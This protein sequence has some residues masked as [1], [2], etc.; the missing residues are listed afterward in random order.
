MVETAALDIYNDIAERTN[1]DIYIGVV[2]PVR[3]GK[4]TFITSFMEKLILPNVKN[5]NIK[6]RAID[7]LP[8]SAEGKTIMTTQ[9]KFVPNEAVRL[10]LGD[11]IDVSA[12]LIDCVGYL[13]DGAM[14][15]EENQKARLV[16]TPWSKD[17]IPFEEAAEIGTQKVVSE[18]STIAVVVT[19]DGSITEIARQSYI[20]AEKRVVNEL[21]QLNKPFIVVL[22]STNP[23]SNECK[24]LAN[25]MSAEYGVSV[26]PLDVKNITVS[27][28]EFLLKSI[29]DEFPV[30][31][32]VFDI[33]KW[34]R[35][36][37]SDNVLICGIID[38]IKAYADDVNKMKNC[39]LLLSAFAEDENF[40]EPVV[41]SLK[42]GS[43]EA[44]YSIQAKPELFFK[45]LSAQAGKDISDEF[46]LMSFVT[47]CSVARKNYDNIKDAMESAAAVG[48]GVVSPQFDQMTLYDPEIVKAGTR[49]G[50]KLKA[51]APT[52]HI[53]RV[54]VSTE[55][56]PMVGSEQQ[57]QYLL[58][59]FQNNPKAI[60]E[61]DMFGKSLASLAR[62]G[63]ANKV[64]AMPIDAQDKLIKTVGRIINEGKG[65][66]ICILL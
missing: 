14:G 29:L 7:E 46:S 32:M 55:V 30:K 41:E 12:R 62:E 57:S 63:L 10:T 54:D 26:L 23:K 28:I 52:L 18:H 22:N 65:S 58:S 51:S 45:T 47:E 35:T 60:W 21:K 24:E 48:Y 50:V 5:K 6:K 66:L 27:Q 15:H 37:P 33:P 3:T 2:G 19:T 56:N 39:N 43:G 34:M 4:S 44:Y 38:K 49:F 20:K 17:S 13:V 64:N 8:Q 59:E 25:S 31:K 16:N 40:Y 61:T 9:P 1:G 36:L 11:K 53:M 42:M